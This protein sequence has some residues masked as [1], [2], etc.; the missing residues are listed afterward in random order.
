MAQGA[1]RRLEIVGVPQRLADLAHLYG[2]DGLL[3]IAAHPNEP[4]GSIGESQRVA[5]PVV[6]ILR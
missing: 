5:P 3:G 4:V 2:V 1:Q 6:P